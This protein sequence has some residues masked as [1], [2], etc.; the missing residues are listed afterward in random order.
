M[1]TAQTCA[2]RHKLHSMPTFRTVLQVKGSGHV[3][4]LPFDPKAVFGRIRVPVRVTVNGETL[5]TTVARYGGRDFVGFN[6]E[7]RS[8][9]G[10][11]AGDEITVQVEHDTEPRTV[12]LPADLAA[13]LAG[14]PD[15]MEIYATLAYTHQREYAA[16]VGEAKREATRQRR[17]ER[18][19]E[20][21]RAGRRHP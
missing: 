9:A 11:S 17:A 10:I 1:L 19:V 12:E 3:V 7:F 18:A 15:A 5:R 6:R 13:A 8:A 4:E 21:L 2:I 20:M 16:W 14:A